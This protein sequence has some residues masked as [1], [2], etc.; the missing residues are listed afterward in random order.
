MRLFIHGRGVRYRSPLLGIQAGETPCC[1]TPGGLV[2]GHGQGPLRS[3]S[4]GK[5]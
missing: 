2:I 3:L 1:P 5:K 4:A